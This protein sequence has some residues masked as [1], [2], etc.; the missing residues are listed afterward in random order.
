MAI[1]QQ[2]STIGAAAVPLF[3][4]ECLIGGEVTIQNRSATITM[5]LGNENLTTGAFG[6]E[7][8]V[9]SEH[10]FFL[11]KNETIYGMAASGTLTYALFASGQPS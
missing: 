8:A 10:T 7:V 1:V 6:H 4:Q 5:K 2:I 11:H 9:S 3:T